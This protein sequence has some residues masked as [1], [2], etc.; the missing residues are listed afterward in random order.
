MIRP[1]E[2]NDAPSIRL[3][4]QSVPN[5]WR[6]SWRPDVLERAIASADGLAFVWQ[7]GDLLLGFVCAHDLGFH[8]YLSQLVVAD[9]ARRKGIGKELVLRVQSE[10]VER[11]CN[12]L[13]ADATSETESFYRSL[14]W[15]PSQAT[16]LK[17]RLMESTI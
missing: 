10:L 5:L 1:V 12:L 15:Q 11:G 17:R 7:E 9:N 3:L 13:V 4:M 8:G 2:P 16:F 6:E 14:G